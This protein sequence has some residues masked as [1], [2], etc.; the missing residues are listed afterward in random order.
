MTIVL[1][2]LDWN[3]DPVTVLSAAI[4]A[5]VPDDEAVD[6]TPL[7]LDGGVVT[8][9]RPYGGLTDQLAAVPH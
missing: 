7:L 3:G 1:L 2:V 6:A 9:V 8:V 5:V 4:R